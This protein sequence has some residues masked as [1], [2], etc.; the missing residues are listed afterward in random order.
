MKDKLN[1]K[2]NRMLEDITDEKM[3]ARR[4]LA[5]KSQKV[6]YELGDTIFKQHQTEIQDE[7]AQMRQKY[8]DAFDGM[9]NEWFNEKA[10][11]IMNIFDPSVDNRYLPLVVE[12]KTMS[13]VDEVRDILER[14]KE[15]GKTAY[16][17]SV[18]SMIIGIIKSLKNNLDVDLSNF[19]DGDEVSDFQLQ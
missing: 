11:E 4:E 15:M 8:G 16:D 19:L 10:L 5:K 12:L 6:G 14:A 18:S 17:S 2:W 9:M 13:I 7:L 3:F 1:E